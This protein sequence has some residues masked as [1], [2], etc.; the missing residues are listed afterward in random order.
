LNRTIDG[1][2]SPSSRAAGIDSRRRGR[3]AVRPLI[4]VLALAAL[5][6]GPALAHDCRVVGN[7]YLRGT[8]EGEC[9]DKEVAHGQGEARGTDSY[10]GSF[11]KGVPEGNGVYTWKS[12]G[13]L[14]GTFK[15][16]KANGPGVFSSVK[17]TRYEGE[18]ENG[19]L[20]GMKTEDCPTTP[21]PVSC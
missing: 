16:G 5:A 10:V 8:Y 7:P 3:R 17:G 18:F 9:N 21:G 1:A 11:V 6:G 2:D 4:E 19:K 15:G 14:E 20:A 12:G 13:R